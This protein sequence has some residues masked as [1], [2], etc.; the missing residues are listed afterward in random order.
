MTYAHTLL[1]CRFDAAQ[2]VQ[3]IN[4]QFAVSQGLERNM[5]V[6]HPAASQHPKLQ[7]AGLVNERTEDRRRIYHI[8]PE[9]FGPWRAWFDQFWDQAL[10]TF[11]DEIEHTGP[12]EGGNDP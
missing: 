6:R 2:H 7:E 11:Q 4:C 12:A 5:P 9:G 8:D 3:A 1:A 10:A